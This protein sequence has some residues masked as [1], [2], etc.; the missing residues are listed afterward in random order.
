MK[1]IF[2]FV[3]LITFALS[4]ISQSTL[5]GVVKDESNLETIIGASIIAKESGQA[6]LTDLDGNFQITVQP[7]DLTLI[8]SAFGYENK[9]IKIDGRQNYEITLTAGQAL[10]EV[11]VVGYGTVKKSDKT[12]AIESIKPKDKDVLQY[13]NFQDFLQGRAAGVQVLSNGNELLSTSSI[14]IR[15][16]NSL[17]GDNEPLYVIDGIIVNSS[18]EDVADPLSGGNSYLSAQ[19]G[20]SG[21]NTQDIE[22][23]EV[24]KD[25]SATA[26]YGSRGANGVVLITTKKGANGK[27]KF[28]YKGTAR[29]G[30]ATRLYEMLDA[31]SFANYINEFRAVQKFDPS[32]YTYGDG[33]I[34]RYTNSKDFMEAKKD[35]I[36]RLESINWYNDVLQQS[37]SQNHRLTV[38]GGNE[39]SNYYIGGGYNNAK[40][41]VPGTTLSGGDILL[42]YT[43]KLT[44][45]LSISPRFSA[46]YLSNKASKGTDNLGSS[47][48]SLIRQI[49]EA[50]PLVGYTENNLTADI[51]DAVDGPRAW[52]EDYN[53]DSNEA[54]A[55]ASIT[56]D[57]KISNV[58]TYRILGG[59][60][61]RNK[62]RKLWYGTTLQRGRLANGEAGIGT[63]NRIRYNV[64]NTLMF[65]KEI[66]R[67]NKINGTL[68]FI[69]DE[70][71][72]NQSG[73]TSTNFA[74]QELRYNGISFGQSFSP[75]QLFE[76][77][78][79]ILSVLGRVNYSLNNKYLFTASFR[80]DG[81]SKFS[82]DNKWSFFPSAAFAW[83]ID[84]EKFLKNVKFISEAKLRLG[85]GKT[86]SQ[87]IQPYQTLTRFSPTA[88]LQSNGSTGGVTAVLPNNLG[89]DK[90]KWETTSQFNI[91]LDFGILDD[92]FTGTIDVYQKKT[93]DLLQFLQIGPSAGFTNFLTNLGD[94]QNN[95][96]EIGLNAN[97]IEGN[98]KWK[99]SGN[100]SFN[101][102]K[103]LNLGV[104]ASQHGNEIRKAII[105]Q[106][107]SGGTV[108]KVPANIFIEGQ[109]AGLFWGYK[110]NGIIQ[111]ET[112]LATAPKVQ[113]AASKLGDVLYVD[114]NK[115]GNITDLDL[116]VIGDPNAKY[117]FGLGSE[118]IYKKI[119]LNFFFNGVQGNDIAN[120]NNGRQAI[121]IGL[122]TNNIRK[123][124]YEGAWRAD[125]TD[126][127][128]PRLGYDIK[129]NFTDR[130]VEDGSFIRL[131]FVSLGYTLPKKLLK[132]IEGAN[133]FVSGHN[134]LL[135]T[136][137]TGFDPE[138]NSFSFESSRR[139]IDWSSFP[140]QKSFSA[141]INVEF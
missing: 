134:L 132:G 28:A 2:S 27:T 139:G 26:I 29:I 64:D 109:A 89:N 105:G 136:K 91:G 47:N 53:D 98:F 117:N 67:H 70:T 14:R 93:S 72:V 112:S 130:M 110:T 83:K 15:G 92:R 131:S 57:Y 12:G 10:Q 63:L 44:D 33:S 137:Y 79:A 128:Y 54:R 135:L 7:T 30:N 55:L 49:V 84:K 18:T 48:T 8:I 13:N 37:F 52:I 34:A 75:F 5:T 111:N 17:R 45:R 16:A 119:S 56:A 68:G 108:F 40:G 103:I 133:I 107:V 32:F 20:L 95:G 19:N 50:A 121:P 31:N 1:Y 78:E 101:K 129:G 97:V 35:S 94:L 6:V 123:E 82:D 81:S 3:I 80:R 22:S 66:N 122:P 43:H 90:L 138:V 120:G 42:R 118:F 124:V 51:E 60:D 73:A 141:G 25:A 114:Q 65:D 125:K 61:Y 87:A 58:F 127:T 69:F 116:T 96:L 74:N 36:P 38:S 115:D 126:A 88:N 39:K 24:L 76:S 104:P 102:N 99:V 21:I 77:S 100:I 140:N 59:V 41:I 11:L 4:G 46:N 106:N 113:G 85:Y 62:D 71:K 23:I 86:G 9:E